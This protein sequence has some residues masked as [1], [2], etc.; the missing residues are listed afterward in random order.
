M[1][2]TYKGVRGGTISGEPLCRTCRY[3]QY[4]QGSSLSQRMLLCGQIGSHP[5]PFEAME[6]GK[7]DDKRLPSQYDMEQI[8]WVFV[9]N[10]KTKQIGFVSAKEYQKMRQT[11]S[12]SGD[13][14]SKI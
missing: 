6:C 8:A 3:A 9:T 13:P 7:Y 2:S 12:D 5:L 11:D 1:A 10:S 14:S 4:M